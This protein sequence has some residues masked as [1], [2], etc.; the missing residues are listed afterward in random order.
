MLSFLLMIAFSL[1]L[2]GYG[3]IALF[4]KEW[5]LKIR[6]MSARLEGKNLKNEDLITDGS[7]ARTIMAVLAL[8]LGIIGVIVSIM[9]VVVFM[10]AQGGTISV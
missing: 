2:T 7:T 1:Y 3:F 5:L 9:T 4:K 8:T 6:A 10:Q